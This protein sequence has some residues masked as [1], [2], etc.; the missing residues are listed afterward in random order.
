[1]K[2]Q[3]Y[4]FENLNLV[5]GHSLQLAIEG[6][7]NERGKSLLVGYLDNHSVIVT[8]PLLAGV[9][10]VLG[11]GTVL[12]V[13]MF[14]PRI[15]SVC[16]FRSE[17]IHSA[18]QPYTHLYLRMP[19]DIVVGE[20]RRSVRAQVSLRTHV[21][22]GEKYLFK[23]QVEVSDISVGGARLQVAEPWASVGDAVKLFLQINI[24]GVE[25]KLEIEAVVHSVNYHQATKAVSLQF[26]RV[27]DDD[28]IALYAFVMKN[29]Y[30]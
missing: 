29:L 14:V 25:R 15:G 2:D 18:R 4:H 11:V 23:H 30:H 22:T 16:A 20:V 28:R 6:Y 12:T 8:A 24:E 10:T 26:A 13:R 19:K 21:L 9:P 5:S 3:F 7:S 27:N 1:M 17:V